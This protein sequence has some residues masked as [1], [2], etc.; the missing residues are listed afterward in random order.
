MKRTFPLGACIAIS[1]FW[2]AACKSGTTNPSTTTP[3]YMPMSEG[4]YWVYER[5]QLDSTGNRTGNA[6]YDSSVVGAAIQLG[7]RTATPIYTYSSDGG[8][9]TTYYSKDAEGNLWMYFTVDIGDIASGVANVPSIPARWVKVVSVGT[10][11]SWTVL[12]TTITNVQVEGLPTPIN[13]TVKVTIS[14]A[15]TESITV[16]GKTYTAQKFTWNTQLTPSLPIFTANYTAT[17]WAVSGVGYA[18]HTDR[19]ELAVPLIGMN[20]VNGNE[21][22]LIRFL[23]K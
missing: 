23:V 15:G 7:G 19:I 22:T 11:S 1:I 12:D 8:S 6:A 14:K 18:K 16:G 10:E 3:D 9:D 2:F 4:N 21:S 20:I 17:D 13:V 5:Y